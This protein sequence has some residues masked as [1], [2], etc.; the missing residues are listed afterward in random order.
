M[1]TTTQLRVLILMLSIMFSSKVNGQELE[2]VRQFGTDA[3]S[4]ITGV[5]VHSSGVFVA[6]TTW[7]AL[8]GQTYFGGMDSFV[9]KYTKEGNEVWTRQFG[10]A[11]NDQVTSIASDGSG[12]YVAGVVN[13]NGFIN[14]YD[15][16]GQE[17]WVIS[18]GSNE[19][20]WI[21]QISIDE[22]GL[23]VLG[24][25]QGTFSGQ[26]S[27]GGTD[28]FV[29]KLDFQGEEIWTRQFGTPL[30]DRAGGI[31]I[32]ETKV[33]ITGST[34]GVL[35][36]QSNQGFTDAFIRKYTTDGSLVWTQQFG[37]PDIDAAIEIAVNASG[38]FVSGSTNGNIIGPNTADDQSFLIKYDHNGSMM[39]GRQ[40]GPGFDENRPTAIAVDQTHIY[41]AGYSYGVP[42]NSIPI[43]EE[44]DNPNLEEPD[45]DE[46]EFDGY[47]RKYDLDGNEIWTGT[48]ASR[49]FDW[50]ADLVLNGSE[51]YLGGYTTGNFIEETTLGESDALFV[52]LDTQKKITFSLIN[53]ATNQPVPGYDPIQEDTELNL[54]LLPNN[55]SIRANGMYESVRFDFDQQSKFRTEN[56]SPFALFGDEQGDYSPGQLS[57]E[58]HTLSATAFD[59]D[60]ATGN[61]I[62]AGSLSFTVINEATQITFSLINAATN[63]PIPGYDPMIGNLVS[64]NLTNLPANLSIRANAPAH[65]ESV[66]FLLKSHGTMTYQQIENLVPYSLGGD[67]D[68]NYNSFNFSHYNYSLSLEATA[69]SSDNANGDPGLQGNI[70]LFLQKD[71]LFV[72]VNTENQEDIRIIEYGDVL[73]LSELPGQFGIKAQILGGASGVNFNLTGPLNINRWEGP[74]PPYSLFGDVGNLINPWPGEL[75]KP[76]NY[77]LWVEA[78]DQFASI[79]FKII[80]ESQ[81]IQANDIPPDQQ[82]KIRNSQMEISIYPNPVLQD[83]IN[84]LFEKPVGNDLVYSILDITGRII[85]SDRVKGNNRSSYHLD[86]QKDLSPGVYFIKINSSELR[87]TWTKRIIKSN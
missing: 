53:T 33:Y 63:K 79:A 48:I 20:D 41:L 82:T 47:I 65:F 67:S 39:W 34:A 3:R 75:L 80:L 16:D 42:S 68:G 54:A 26:I 50:V 81:P 85:Q 7:G 69:Y 11:Q 70:T 76:G 38:I 44:Y 31:S 5:S 55:L 27:A 32:F 1:K 78:D 61:I 77:N 40:F 8:P 22:T 2:W 28:V 29:M 73:D 84:L 12:L 52:K 18:F 19:F 21:S 45:F 6:G 62:A 71:P 10:S 49:F 24:F 25:T 4:S 17:Q 83:Q 23:Y 74:L 64:I 37:S 43:I 58:S 66:R 30:S 51:L 15:F 72:L 59:Q 36:G 57:V 86:L 14:K 9:R 87:K 46:P 56:F 13:Q 60:N 35:S